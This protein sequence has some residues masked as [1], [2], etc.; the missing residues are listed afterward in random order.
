MRGTLL[1]VA[2]LLCAFTLDLLM[3][4]V[5]PDA[6]LAERL[7]G[8]AR[9]IDLPGPA[10][11]VS[12]DSA[13]L[14]F[15]WAGVEG[16]VRGAVKLERDLVAR[17]IVLRSHEGIDRAA[18]ESPGFLASFRGK[19]ASPPVVVEAVSGATISSQGVID[20]VNERLRAWMEYNE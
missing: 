19:L 10:A 12:G 16:P 9:R 6:V 1:T 20:S 11:F 17:V 8:S 4:R 18:L 5:D 7:L 3:P 2:L 14:F 13:L 15:E